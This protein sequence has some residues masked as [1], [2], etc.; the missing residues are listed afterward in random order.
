VP[1]SY[2]A[3]ASVDGALRVQGTAYG[4]RGVYHSTVD[5]VMVAAD[6]AAALAELTGAPADMGA[7]ASKLVLPQPFQLGLCPM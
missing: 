7:L 2:H 6:R 5:G 1:G 3:I 4:T